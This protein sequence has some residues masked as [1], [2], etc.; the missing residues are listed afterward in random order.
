MSNGHTFQTAFGQNSRQE[1][2]LTLTSQTFGITR[3]ID[4]VV[5]FVAFLFLLF[6]GTSAKQ[7]LKYFAKPNYYFDARG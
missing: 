7:S 2:N 4:G 6:L 1:R 3:N 5:A